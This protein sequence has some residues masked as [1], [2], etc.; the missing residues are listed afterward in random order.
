MSRIAVSGSSLGG[1]YAAR[2]GAFEPRLA[3]CISHGAQWSV[4]LNYASMTEDHKLAGHRKWIFGCK[5]VEEVKEKAK[6]FALEGVLDKIKC[7]YLIVH[8]GYDVLGVERV[9]IVSERSEEHTSE[10]QSL[11]GLTYDVLCLKKKN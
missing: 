5:T 9:R 4:G 10:L 11:M 6:A 7:P 3:A 2:A 1:Y 8:G